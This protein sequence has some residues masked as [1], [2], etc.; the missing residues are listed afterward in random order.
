MS[1][2]IIYFF[3]RIFYH[4]FRRIYKIFQYIPVL[5]YNEDWDYFYLYSLMQYKIK[6]M[7]KY[8]EKMQ[9]YVGWELR[10]KDMKRAEELLENIKNDEY[11]DQI[12]SD[13]Q[14]TF[15]K[16]DL[17]RKKDKEE[18]MKLL[19]EKSDHWWH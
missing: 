8:H 7:R 3:R 16:A 19:I 5:W 1:K 9:D 18:L 6:R 2:S 12:E 10:V 14:L 17:L 4:P 15:L 13:N 11:D